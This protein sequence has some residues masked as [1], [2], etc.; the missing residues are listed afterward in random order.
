MRSGVSFTVPPRASGNLAEWRS[1]DAELNNPLGLSDEADMNFPTSPKRSSIYL[2][3]YWAEG[4]ASSPFAW[5]ERTT[6][7]ATASADGTVQVRW[8]QPRPGYLNVFV[9]TRLP[10]RLPGILSFSAENAKDAG[11][12]WRAARD[13]WRLL[14]VTDVELPPHPS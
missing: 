13:V 11:A 4:D 1:K 7:L 5:M 6:R 9:V 2:E 3:V 14:R 12:A 8:A 10:G